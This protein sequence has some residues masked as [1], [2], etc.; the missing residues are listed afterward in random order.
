MIDSEWERII[1]STITNIGTISASKGR[2]YTQNDNDRLANFKRAGERTELHP[3][4]V[5]F[6][7]FN[8]HVDSI[9]T[10]VNDTARGDQRRMSE[11]I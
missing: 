2:E 11:P 5:W 6:V 1:A 7:Y 4:K 10:Y 3:M 9:T 8:K